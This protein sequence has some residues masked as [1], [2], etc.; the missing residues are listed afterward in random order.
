LDVEQTV[1]TVSSLRVCALLLH[2]Q[3]RLPLDLVSKE[4]KQQLLLAKQGSSAAAAGPK[5]ARAA[6]DASVSGFSCLYSWGN[7]A[8]LTLGTGEDWSCHAEAQ[9]QMCDM[10]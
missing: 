4:L 2:P 6:A 7:G 8:N 3:G 9:G 5:Q 10:V 1:A